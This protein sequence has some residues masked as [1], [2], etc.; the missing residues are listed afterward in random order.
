MAAD[1]WG[2]IPQ[3]MRAAKF[4]VL[5][6]A[7]IGRELFNLRG[8]GLLGRRDGTE[9]VGVPQVR[10]ARRAPAAADRLHHVAGARRGAHGGAQ[11]LR[12]VGRTARHRRSAAPGIL[13]ATVRALPRRP[14][15]PPVIVTVALL[16]ALAT[17]AAR[18][19]PA[20]PSPPA[21]ERDGGPPVPTLPQTISRDSEGRA[22]VIAVRVPTP[23]RIDGV[24][25]ETIYTTAHPASGFIQMEPR[26]GEEATEKTEVWVSFDDN[27][28]YVSFKAWETQPE[29]RVANEL[30]RDSGNIRQGDSVGFGFDT[31]HDRRNALQFE[32]NA[33]GARSEGQSTNE[34]QFNADWNPV[35]RV[36]A[37]TFDGGWTIEA[38]IPFKSLRYAPGTTQVWGFQAR[39]ISKWK[40]EIAYLTKV[41]NAFGLGRADF[42]ASLYATLVG[43]EVPNLART[44]ELK[45][46]AITDV[47]TDNVS[48]PARTNDLSGDIGLDAK[49]AVSQ[50]LT[51]DFTLNTDFAQVEA[52]E[53]QVNL[54][55][56]TL[57][58]PE[59]RDF[60]LENQGVFTFGNNVFGG[61]GAVTS[62]VPL[63]FYSRRIGLVQ[64]ATGPA[65]VP[66]LGGGRLTGRIGKYQVGLVNMQTRDDEASGADATNF[67]VARVRRDVLRRSSI[68]V[69]ATSRSRAQARPGS[70]QF[71]GVDGTFAF[72][73]NL[74][75]NT[76]WAQTSSEGDG[77]LRSSYR[78]QM[79]YTADRY[80]VQFE[81]LTIDPDF[82]PEVGFLR[83]TD[84]RK[85]Y[86][87]FR[88][89]PRPRRNKV[90]RKYFAVGQYTYIQDS[91]GRLS[92]RLADGAFD[93]EFQSSDRFTIGVLDDY[94][95]LL[96]PFTVAGLRIP[97][98]GYRFTTGRVGYTLGQQRP[99]SGAVLFERGDFYGG[100][101]SALT[102]SRSR[103]NVTSTFS[104]E[105]SLTL[106]WLDLP[107]GRVT[108]TLVGSRLTYTMTPLMFASALVQYNSVTRI[109]SVNARLRWEYRLG[110]ELFLVYNDERDQ[111]ATMGRPELQNRALILKVNRFLRF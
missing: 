108:S 31:F 81:H 103:V 72:F 11:R 1:E 95:L 97:A 48:R 15:S 19:Q 91:A 24:L 16:A 64:G 4:V 105:P 8:P 53:Q 41:P 98:G 26:A 49:Y 61:A 90:I 32:T 35:W 23:M 85:Q 99:F 70:N 96:R 9:R 65:N 52:D 82:N 77:R 51:A 27:N 55:R 29:R 102:M 73:D 66:I 57:F 107:A 74:L 43:L 68:G 17:P 18:A 46:F 88:F 44:L 10:T 100:T 34:R 86:A 71:Y 111:G 89:S 20:A 50:N 69:M 75:F 101:R 22:T 67:A 59:K 33:L 39:R 110:S 36:A 94:E 87:Q 83:R 47:T 13:R 12:P 63:P 60:F 62:D 54:T 3:M 6:A 84:L 58:F 25:D 56:F 93:I 38:I 106:N 2:D 92:T 78:A 14:G 104:M 109:V 21:A 79:D 28:L 7:T 37:G 30:R 80:G 76:Y 42:S 40:N 45:P 5:L